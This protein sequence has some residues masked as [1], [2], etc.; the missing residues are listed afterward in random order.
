MP[1]EAAGGYEKLYQRHRGNHCLRLGRRGKYFNG[2]DDDSDQ[3]KH[4]L[5]CVIVFFKSDKMY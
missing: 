4:C 3:I 5:S 1:A 2:D